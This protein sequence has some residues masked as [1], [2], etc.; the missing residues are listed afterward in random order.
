M[1]PSVVKGL[2]IVGVLVGRS[3]LLSS[4]L[5]SHALG[6]DR[7]P[8]GGWGAAPIQLAMQH[9]CMRLS[10]QPVGA[11]GWCA[12]TGGQGHAFTH[13]LQ[14]LLGLKAGVHPLE[15]RTGTL[16]SYLRSFTAIASVISPV[17]NRLTG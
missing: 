15:G 12:A 3:E 16:F 7:V 17:G 9:R 1:H 4:W 11:R 8:T 6:G 2:V 5:Q 10:A 13:G 14:G